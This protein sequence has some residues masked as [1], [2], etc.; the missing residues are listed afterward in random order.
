MANGKAKG[1]GWWVEDDGGTVPK[2][3]ERVLGCLSL[4][5]DHTR[6]RTVQAT[7]SGD[8]AH[9]QV[10]WASVSVVYVCSATSTRWRPQQ[11]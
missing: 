1:T 8:V 3:S 11:A 5:N 6:R 4:P 10:S 7:L 2:P 9:D